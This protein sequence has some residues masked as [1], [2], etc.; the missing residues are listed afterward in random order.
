VALD[1]L[2]LE[3][4]VNFPL[5]WCVGSITNQTVLGLVAFITLTSVLSSDFNLKCLYRRERGEPFRPSPDTSNENQMVLRAL[6]GIYGFFLK[7]Q[8]TLIRRFA[9][10]RLEGILN[11]QT[12][13]ER[14]RAARRAYHD[15]ETLFVLANLELSTQLFVLGVC[16]VLGQPM[17]YLWLVM[18]C[19]IVLIGLQ[20][21][22]EHRAR[23]VLS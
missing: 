11:V 12:D 2:S 10:V 14:I 4:I 1:L 23:Q 20:L 15:A 16:L 8:D 5:F 13:P 18:A 6:E 22:R 3:V 21:R 7:P 17:Y 19:G 9:D